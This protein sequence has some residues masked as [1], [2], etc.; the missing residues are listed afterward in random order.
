MGQ[1]VKQI[2]RSQVMFFE[3]GLKSDQ[4]MT[5]RR[6]DRFLLQC[7]RELFGT[8]E[9]QAVV[10]HRTIFV[11]TPPQFNCRARNAEASA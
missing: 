9:R 10:T 6:M 1:N 8:D 4:P 2:E 11:T 3:N 5:R 7:E